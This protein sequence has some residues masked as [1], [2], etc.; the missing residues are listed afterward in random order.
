[1]RQ[2]LQKGA[3]GGCWIILKVV[4]KKQL[5]A[6]GLQ[7]LYIGRLT[8]EKEGFP[9]LALDGPILWLRVWSPADLSAGL[10]A[11]P[12]SPVCDTDTRVIAFSLNQR[13]LI[14]ICLMLFFLLSITTER[15]ERVRAQHCAARSEASSK[16]SGGKGQ[17]HRAPDG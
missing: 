12:A 4:D 7:S 5:E 3:T 13:H 15:E 8:S 14:I 6:V 2:W 16:K 17:K 11:K 9:Q 10:A 1:M